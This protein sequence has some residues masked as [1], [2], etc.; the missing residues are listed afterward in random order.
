[1]SKNLARDPDDYRDFKQPFE[2]R[3]VN[4]LQIMTELEKEMYMVKLKTE[5]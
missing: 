2:L 5:I 1:M 4:E 3:N